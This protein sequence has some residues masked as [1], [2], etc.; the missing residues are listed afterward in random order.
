MSIL[1]KFEKQ[2][3]DT[4]DFDVDYRDWLAGMTDTAPG[5]DGV[6]VEA[7]VGITIIASTLVD[8]IVKVWLSGGEDGATYKITTTVTTTDGRTKQAE[9]RVKVK[10]Y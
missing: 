8:G 10:E 2:P 4:Q 3:A 6:V 1:G 5:P 9:F 7:D